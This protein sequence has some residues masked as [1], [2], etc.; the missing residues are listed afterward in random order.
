MNVF[1]QLS[2]GNVQSS[3]R[4]SQEVQ[5]TWFFYNGF[6]TVIVGIVSMEPLSFCSGFY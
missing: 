1:F 2:E 3:S 4:D 6:L 5:S